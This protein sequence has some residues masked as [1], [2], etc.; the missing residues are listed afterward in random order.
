MI[1]DNP[2]IASRLV[3]LEAKSF[4]DAN[5]YLLLESVVSP[6]AC[7]ELATLA[8][9]FGQSPDFPVVL[10]IHRKRRAFGAFM[11]QPTLVDAVSTLH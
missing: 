5:G 1:L 9:P 7:E 4:Y 10:N 2:F 3:D 11:M 8:G 6:E